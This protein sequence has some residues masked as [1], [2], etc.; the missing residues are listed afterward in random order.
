MPKK[1]KLDHIRDRLLEKAG[2]FTGTVIKTF[3]TVEE[4]RKQECDKEFVE[5]MDNRMVMGYFRYGP[6]DKQGF[7][8]YDY[9]KEAIRRIKLY[10]QDRNRE[11]LV[12]AGNIVR[13]AY[14]HARKR[15]DPFNSVDDG[16]HN[17]RIDV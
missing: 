16:A 14:V 13:L 1:R 12:D 6:V 7:D 8:K 3:L 5:F 15:G 4:I 11:H 2:I 17:E 9:C 10:E